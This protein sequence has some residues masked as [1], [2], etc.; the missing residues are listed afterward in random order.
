MDK[1]HCIVSLNI[2][3]LTLKAMLF[4]FNINLRLHRDK[5]NVF[6]YLFFNIPVHSFVILQL[7][8]YTM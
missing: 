8:Y 3:F 4:S 1:E 2:T 6:Y 5:G 7:Y